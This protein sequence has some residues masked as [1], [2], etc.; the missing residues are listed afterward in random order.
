[1]IYRLKN[2]IIFEGSQTFF[3]H[4]V[5]ISTLSNQKGKIITDS[6][7]MDISTIY[8][9]D[10]LYQV[11]SPFTSA[12]N[13]VISVPEGFKG[14]AVLYEYEPDAALPEAMSSFLSRVIEGGMKLTP[15]EVLTANICYTDASLQKLAEIAKAKT[16]IIFGTKWLYSLHNANI[17]KNEIV[18]LYGMKVLVTDTLEVINTN[19]AAKKAFWVE[20]K[21][22]V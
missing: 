21:K 14:M 17:S 10:K 8:K 1:M 4:Q 7:K 19:D 5:V 12:Q 9:A 2:I 20:L 18:K 13:G 22:L 11:S 16:V 3:L 15:S 6:T